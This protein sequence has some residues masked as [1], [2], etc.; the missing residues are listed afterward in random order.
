MKKHCT[1]TTIIIAS[2][3]V[4]FIGKT[5]KNYYLSLLDTDEAALGVL[6]LVLAPHVKRGVKKREKIHTKSP[7]RTRAFDLQGEISRTEL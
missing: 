5:K 6:C 2:N 3:M 7:K 1:L 4:S